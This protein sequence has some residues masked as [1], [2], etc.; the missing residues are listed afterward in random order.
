M[1]LKGISPT[2]HSQSLKCLTNPMGGGC[3]E[4][5]TS[6]KPPEMQGAPDDRWCYWTTTATSARRKPETGESPTR[7]FRGVDW[8]AS[9]VAGLAGSFLKVQL[10][11]R[12]DFS[13]GQSSSVTETSDVGRCIRASAGLNEAGAMG[14]LYDTAYQMPSRFPCRATLCPFLLLHL[15]LCNSIQSRRSPLNSARQVV[16]R[17]CQ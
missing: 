10:L 6:M 2:V 1:R 15:V 13:G 14:D 17:M 7:R 8:A 9:T 4:N 11:S 12:L 3:L 5:E 16:S